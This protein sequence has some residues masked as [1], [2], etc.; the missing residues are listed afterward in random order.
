MS[1]AR[2]PDAYAVANWVAVGVELSCHCHCTP[3][4][5]VQPAATVAAAAGADTRIDA[6]TSIRAQSIAVGLVLIGALRWG[7]VR[8]KMDRTFRACRNTPRSSRCR[9]TPR[10]RRR[11]CA[12]GWTDIGFVDT[13]YAASS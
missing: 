6:S 13:A 4:V 11:W 9:R 8:R 2:A 7:Q 3:G 12:G 1:K 10:S 5:G